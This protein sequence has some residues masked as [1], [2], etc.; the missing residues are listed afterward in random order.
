MAK[1]IQITED[2]VSKMSDLMEDMLTLGGKLMHC[3]SELEEESYSER[4]MRG[5]RGMRGS[6]G[7]KRY[8]DFEEEEYGE[9]SGRRSY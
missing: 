5:M 4:G 1:I 6:A 2:K 3:I 7:S 9:R 8:S